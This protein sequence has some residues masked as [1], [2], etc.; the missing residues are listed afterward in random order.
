MIVRCRIELTPDRVI[1][2]RPEWGYHL[3]AALLDGGT[4]NEA[5]DAPE[6]VDADFNL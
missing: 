6:T 2:C 3:Y 1:A 5:A 4:E